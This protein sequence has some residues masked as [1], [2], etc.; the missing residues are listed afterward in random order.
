LTIQPAK[1]QYAIYSQKFNYHIDNQGPE[2]NQMPPQDTEK[3]KWF[4]ENLYPHEVMLRAWLRDRFPSTLDVDDIIQDSYIKVM[5]AFE[6]DETEMRSPKAFLFA[7]ARNQAIDWLRRQKI[8]RYEPLVE[9]DP[10]FVLHSS[11]AAIRA[12]KHKENLE[13]MTEAIQSLP[14]RCRQVFTLRKVY[15]YSHE[16]IAEK[17]GI[18]INTVAVQVSIGI[19]KCK[20]FIKEQRKGSSKQ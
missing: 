9:S 16:E 14:D 18:S 19:R 6:S 13:L 12:V 5:R 3:A 20:F 17:L 7:T 4:E 8:V 1:N 2:L 11:D 15:G 10:S